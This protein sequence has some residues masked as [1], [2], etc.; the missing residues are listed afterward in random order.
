MA[1]VKPGSTYGTH[2]EAGPQL[3]VSTLVRTKNVLGVV[4]FSV[5][6]RSLRRASHSIFRKL[7][8]SARTKGRP[9]HAFL[10]ICLITRVACRC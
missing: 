5:D 3:L 9:A 2:T 8:L 4:Y 6:D 10:A 7:L 1:S